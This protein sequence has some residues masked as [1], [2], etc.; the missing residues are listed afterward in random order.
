ML[1]ALQLLF[2]ICIANGV[3]VLARKLLGE[4]W[5]QPIDGGRRLP[6]GQFLFGATKTWRGLLLAIAG[7]GLAGLLIGLPVAVSLLIGAAAML[8]DL[9]SSFTKRRLRR[10]SSSKA[11]GLDQI[12]EALLPLLLSM[13]LLGHGWP[14]VIVVCALFVALDVG[15]SPFLY[16]I[17]I[18]RQ[19]H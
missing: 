10:P 12:P 7:T 13:P 11:A 2:L 15:L 8:G 14:T 9:L 5:Q 1:L 4:H 6:D 16:R 18:R 3:P 19:P 17:G